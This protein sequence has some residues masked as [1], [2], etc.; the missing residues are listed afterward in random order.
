MGKYS[1]IL[2]FLLLLVSCKEKDANDIINIDLNNTVAGIDY[3]T[4]VES[5]DYVNLH[6]TDSLPING[7]ECLYF[8]EDKIF[9]KDSGREGILVFSGK[10]GQL[11]KR[12]NPFGE[13]PEEI[14]RISSFCLDTYHKLICVFDQGDKAVKMYDYSGRYVSSYPTNMFFIDMAKL[15]EDGMTYFY[16]IYANGEQYNGIWTVDSLNCLKKQLDSHVTK[17]CIFHYFPILYNKSDTCVY[18]YDRNWDEMSVVTADT[19]QKL[20]S[21]DIR[22]KIPLEERG[23]K[24]L[25]LEDLIGHSIVYYFAYSDQFIL[26]SFHTFNKEI[27]KKDITWVLMNLKTGEQTISKHL[28]ND[29]VA[30]NE[31][32]AGFTLFYMDNHTWIRVDDSSME[33]IIRL[34]ILHLKS[35]KE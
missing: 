4:F 21:F 9:A 22:Q 18:Y 17:E 1:C 6:I 25:Q 15:D 8:D 14:K 34:E 19:C 24:D 28:R 32:N 2:Y 26:F 3:S 20:Y 23:R 13:G 30:G 12:L 10:T 5:V 7:V 16:P 27:R 29:L 11:I 33:D 31:M 35:S